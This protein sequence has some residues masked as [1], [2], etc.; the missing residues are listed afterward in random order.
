M[1]CAAYCREELSIVMEYGMLIKRWYWY[2][3]SLRNVR[4]G[5]VL[6]DRVGS[7]LA[8]IRDTCIVPAAGASF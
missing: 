7:D 3:Y 5:C 6:S 1:S 8:F 4:N 2:W